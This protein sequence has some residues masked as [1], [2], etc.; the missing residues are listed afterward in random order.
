[1]AKTGWE[2]VGGRIQ[3]ALKKEGGSARS[4][5]LKGNRG[6][7]QIVLK[8]ET[9]NRQ[10]ARTKTYRLLGRSGKMYDV[11]VNTKDDSGVIHVRLT[12]RTKNL[13][14]RSFKIKKKG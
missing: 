11:D 13:A 2:K 14:T 3:S 12:G 8:G 7:R 9:G 10:V 5:F 1:M 6:N 4:K